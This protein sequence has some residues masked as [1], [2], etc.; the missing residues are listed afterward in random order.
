MGDALVLTNCH[1]VDN[2]DSI[3]VFFKTTVDRNGW[4]NASLD[5][6]RAHFGKALDLALV[7]VPQ[8][9]PRI[10][11]YACRGV[12]PDADAYQ[13]RKLQRSLLDEKGRLVGVNT[14]TR[15]DGQN[16]NYAVAVSEVREFLG[17]SQQRLTQQAR[18][19]SSVRTNAPAAR[20][21]QW[22]DVQPVKRCESIS[23]DRPRRLSGKESPPHLPERLSG[24]AE[25]GRRS[26]SRISVGFR[27][28][29]NG[30]RGHEASAGRVALVRCGVG[31]GI[32][33][34]VG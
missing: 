32:E 11:K 20:V 19:D 6:E 8:P 21:P 10:Q 3:E 28:V 23:T 26:A 13:P 9:P 14:F 30:L 29:P 22:D 24:A 2:C 16:M 17:R 5:A 31:E 15:T 34:L 7:L 1:V 33:G 27:D 25:N 4:R 18:G 12:A